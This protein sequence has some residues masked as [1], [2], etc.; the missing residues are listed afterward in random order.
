MKKIIALC[1]LSLALPSMAQISLEA[2]RN[3]SD[4]LQRQETMSGEI[5]AQSDNAI[6]NI[7]PSS[8]EAQKA[9][10]A[11]MSQFVLMNA[12]VVGYGQ[13]CG[14]PNDSIREI[15]EF[16]V[17]RYELQNEKYILRKY[18]EKITEFKDSRPK[19][20]ECKIFR[21]EFNSILSK[22]REFK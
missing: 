14:F 7:D 16:I 12:A 6:D 20:D 3:R 4:D 19:E 8:D 17:K 21:K 9:K 1:L 15:K 22:V 13:A 10:F 2:E 11:S 5:Q 18:E